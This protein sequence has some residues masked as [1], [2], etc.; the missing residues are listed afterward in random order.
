MYGEGKRLLVKGPS[1]QLVAPNRIVKNNDG[2]SL[3]SKCY[4]LALDVCDRD[5]FV[6]QNARLYD[7]VM[8]LRFV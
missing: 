2:L 8:T 3:S 7:I 4:P 5:T 6:D 1:A